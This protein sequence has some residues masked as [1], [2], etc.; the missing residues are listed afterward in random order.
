MTIFFSLKNG[1]YEVRKRKY[2]QVGE[3]WIKRGEKYMVG[4]EKNRKRTGY[5]CCLPCYAKLIYAE[6]L[7]EI[8]K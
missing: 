4:I 8:S 5:I 2:C 7:L 6:N 3:H 1:V